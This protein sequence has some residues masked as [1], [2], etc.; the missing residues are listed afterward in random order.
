MADFDVSKLIVFTWES[1]WQKISEISKLY[2][3]N[4]SQLYSS[5]PFL[6]A[7]TQ[8]SKMMAL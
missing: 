3:S 8:R 4:L 5:V 6:I 7:E 2:R 1:K